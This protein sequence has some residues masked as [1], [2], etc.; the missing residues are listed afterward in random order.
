MQILMR[1]SEYA[2]KY[3]PKNVQIEL[4]RLDWEA[5]M[6]RIIAG[7][8]FPLALEHLTPERW[9]QHLQE[10]QEILKQFTP[11][12]DHDYYYVPNWNFT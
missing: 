12:D 6:K 11:P 2:T 8:P 5:Y 7:I 3:T 10:T 1:A 9:T 4:D